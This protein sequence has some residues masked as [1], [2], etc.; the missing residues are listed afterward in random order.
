MVRL[1]PASNIANNIRG[2]EGGGG[3]EMHWNLPQQ[4]ILYETLCVGGK[5]SAFVVQSNLT[6]QP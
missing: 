4:K 2:G 5:L 6:F 1:L 3:E